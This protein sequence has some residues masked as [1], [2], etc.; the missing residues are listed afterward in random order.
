MISPLRTGLLAVIAGIIP[1][2]SYGATPALS[3]TSGI[4]SG[5]QQPHNLTLGWSFTLA[6]PILVTDLGLWDGPGGFPNSP[7]TAGDGFGV[8]HDV[9]IWDTAGNSLTTATVPNGTTATLG[10]D[11]FRYVSLVSPLA[12]A[13]GT[14]VISAY[15]TQASFDLDFANAGTITTVAPVTYGTA[16]DTT[17]NGIT[18][19]SA[20]FH[21]SRSVVGNVFPTSDIES[22][23][24]SFFGPNFEFTAVPEPSTWIV[25]IGAGVV[26]LGKSVRRR[27]RTS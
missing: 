10:T 25:A 7:N 1:T 19:T 18:F 14:Y 27:R 13:A 12:L 15:Y 26:A 4:G 8:S 23:P 16:G 11:N 22:A 6:S 9:T 3:F 5:S 24:K 2:I 20:P 21:G 17:T